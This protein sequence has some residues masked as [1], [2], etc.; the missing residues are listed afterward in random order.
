M[1]KISGLDKLTKQLDEAQKAFAELD[2][3]LGEV[4]FEP[5]D[6]ASIE[7]AI[8]KAGAMID[9]RVGRYSSNPLVGPMIDEIKERYRSAIIAKAAAARLKSEDE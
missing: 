8:N 9:E 3:K 1:I 7:A 5:D 2:G 4:S 6:P